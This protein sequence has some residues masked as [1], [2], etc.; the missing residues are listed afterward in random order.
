MRS[1]SEKWIENRF[2]SAGPG[3]A[4]FFFFFYRAIIYSNEEE[5][6]PF[7]DN[8]VFTA[9]VCRRL[10]TESRGDLPGQ[11]P[12]RSCPM[13]FPVFINDFNNFGNSNRFSSQGGG[14]IIASYNVTM[15]DGVY[16]LKNYF[17]YINFKLCNV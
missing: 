3:E 8:S 12:L 2:E 6:T 1:Q 11:S 10:E 4:L 9:T 16:V 5:G 7:R 15:D 14:V 17:I 13:S